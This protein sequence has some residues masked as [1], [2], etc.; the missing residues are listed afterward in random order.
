MRKYTLEKHFGKIHFGSLLPL[1]LL[2]LLLLNSIHPCFILS[3]HCGQMSER[4][5]VSVT[6]HRH[7]VNYFVR[8]QFLFCDECFS[9]ISKVIKFW[10]ETQLQKQ[11]IPT[12]YILF[13]VLFHKSDN[14]HTLG[15]DF[16]LRWLKD[17]WWILTISLQIFNY[18]RTKI[19]WNP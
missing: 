15:H 19:S 8:L 3:Y 17:K 14:F 13:L 1:L 7:V 10:C 5:Q 11:K 18:F 12:G 2:L 4:S 9:T 16:P 6:V